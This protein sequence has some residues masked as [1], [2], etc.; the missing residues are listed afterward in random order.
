MSS[1]RPTA[2]VRQIEAVNPPPVSTKP[3]GP[4][5]LHSVTRRAMQRA[6]TDRERLTNRWL[7]AVC[8]SSEQA[9]GQQ[10]ADDLDKNL[11]TRKMQRIRETGFWREFALL[12]LEDLGLDAY[13]LEAEQRDAQYALLAAAAQYTRVMTK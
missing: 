7:A 6:S 1:I 8:D 11:P 10:L 9:I 12:I 5:N 3:S 2:A 13:V 4:V